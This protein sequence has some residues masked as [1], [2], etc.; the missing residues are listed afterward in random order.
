MADT[1]T[2]PRPGTLAESLSKHAHQARPAT[3]SPPVIAEPATATETDGANDD[4]A[5][6]TEPVV[7]G[8][9]RTRKY[10]GQKRIV[11]RSALATLYVHDES[12]LVYE[13]EYDSLGPRFWT[14]KE[15]VMILELKERHVGIE[16]ERLTSILQELSVRHLMELSAAA[17]P[18]FDPK[19]QGKAHIRR[20]VV[21]LPNFLRVVNGKLDVRPEWDDDPPKKA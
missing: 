8:A 2:K 15:D 14:P 19:I 1:L 3:A 20:V 13:L 18:D 9:K 5:T 6:P 21:R 7:I 17:R 12:G 10:T 4:A 11:D 16:G